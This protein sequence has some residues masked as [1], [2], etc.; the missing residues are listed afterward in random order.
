MNT[1][2]I[3]TA[4]HSMVL[5]AARLMRDA[6][7]GSVIVS[8]DEAICGILTDRDVVVPAV[9]ERRDPNTSPWQRSAV[10]NRPR[11]RPTTA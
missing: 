3:T 9:A 8:D 5:E 2:A 11:W 7:V 4:S 1:N 10:P 6:S